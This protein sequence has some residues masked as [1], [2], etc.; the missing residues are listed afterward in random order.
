MNMSFKERYTK[1]SGKLADNE[2]QNFLI[3]ERVRE[4][5]P[6]YDANLYA[7]MFG[8]LLV[9]MLVTSISILLGGVV[10]AAWFV[11]FLYYPAR[12]RKKALLVMDNPFDLKDKK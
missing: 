10:A 1:W 4:T 12:C 5:N 3:T 11:A 8:G 9:C 6:R 2:R 7:L